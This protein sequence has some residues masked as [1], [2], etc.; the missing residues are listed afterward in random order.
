MSLPRPTIMGIM[1]DFLGPA[2]AL[3]RMC[4]FGY[5]S[6]ENMSLKRKCVWR[7]FSEEKI[8]LKIYLWR[9][10]ASE[11]KI[12]LKISLWREIHLRRQQSGLQQFIFPSTHRIRPHSDPY[13]GMHINTASNHTAATKVDDSFTSTSPHLRMAAASEHAHKCKSFRRNG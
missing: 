12:A 8:S 9:E 4:L 11:E 10:N 13:L 2:L 7:E 5:F 6:Q 1:W 3:E